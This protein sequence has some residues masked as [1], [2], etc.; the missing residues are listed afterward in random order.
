MPGK[1]GLVLGLVP[2]HVGSLGSQYW[3]APA[4]SPQ[5]SSETH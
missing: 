5:E 4:P 2:S 1:M 3:F